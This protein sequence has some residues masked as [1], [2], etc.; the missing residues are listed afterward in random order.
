MKLELIILIIGS[1]IFA[2]FISSLYYI[3]HGPKKDIIFAKNQ[4]KIY[5]ENV[6]HIKNKNELVHFENEFNSFFE[7]YG[8]Y[9][10][11]YDG[12]HYLLGCLDVLNEILKDD[13]T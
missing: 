12:L 4:M 9:I 10:S 1:A 13:E 8:K 2:Y 6:L 5:K 11:I 7:K 3:I